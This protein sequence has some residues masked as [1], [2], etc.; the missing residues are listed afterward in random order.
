MKKILLDGAWEGLRSSTGSTFPATVPGCV[1]TDLVKAGQLPGDLYWRDHA[2]QAQWIEQEEWVYTKQFAVDT[3][4]EGATLVFAC[5]DTYAD[6]YLN[7]CPVGTAENM[8]IS[9]PTL[10]YQIRLLEEEVGFTIFERS[11]KAQR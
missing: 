10:T 1:H 6:V 9:Q 5:L 2:E 8:F 4:E 7:D 3:P 11:G